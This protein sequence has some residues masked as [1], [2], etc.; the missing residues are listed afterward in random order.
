MFSN[1]QFGPDFA[2]LDKGRVILQK[3][4]E[5]LL[6]REGLASFDDF[7][8]TAKGE[9]LGHRVGRT[10][11]RITLDGA[12]GPV[13]FYLKQYHGAQCLA[14][15]VGVLGK[16]TSPG[17]RELNNIISIERA[18]LATVRAAAVGEAGPRDGSF[19]LLEELSGYQPLHEF[20]KD[21]LTEAEEPNVL[22][23]KRELIRAVAR[24]TRK[25]HR[26][27]IVH[28]DFYLCHIFVRPDEPAQSLR[29]IDLQRVRRRRKVSLYGMVKDLAALNYSADHPGISRT[30]KMRFVCE[31]FGRAGLDWRRR[32]LLR[33]VVFKT[34]RI[35][36]HDRKIQAKARG[37]GRQ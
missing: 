12:A 33:L 21:F 34:M 29:L 31:Y 3:R 14:R 25:M 35:S 22:R 18:G 5:S 28:R 23:T 36:R 11:R 17:R 24:L 4:W 32:W 27:G 9:V 15:L 7:M 16:K 1:G 13:V 2:V 10:R 30:D 37:R 20:L 19:I 26:A 6:G 8:Q